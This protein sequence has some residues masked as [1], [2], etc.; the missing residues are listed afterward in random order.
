M[1]MLCIILESPTKKSKK[2][3]WIKAR[4]ITVNDED[5]DALR[6]RVEEIP[7]ECIYNMYSAQ[8]RVSLF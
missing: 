1:L 6:T 5:L 7:E 4:R 8:Y 2:Y 3:H